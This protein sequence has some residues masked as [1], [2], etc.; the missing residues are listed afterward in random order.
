MQRAHKTFS[1]FMR[2]H[3]RQIT[4]VT[5]L[6]KKLFVNYTVNFCINVCISCASN[7]NASLALDNSLM[8]NDCC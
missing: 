1:I 5:R 8:L 2:P 3:Y 7:D 6:N 4:T